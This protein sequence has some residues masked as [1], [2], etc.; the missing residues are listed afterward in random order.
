MIAHYEKEKY[1]IN[2][3]FKGTSERRIKEVLCF[4]WLLTRIWWWIIE[5]ENAKVEDLNLIYELLYRKDFDRENWRK[6]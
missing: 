6:I 2:Y 1:Y 5:K 3:N 4:R